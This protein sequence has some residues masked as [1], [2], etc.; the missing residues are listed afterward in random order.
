MLISTSICIVFTKLVSLY[1]KSE[2]TTVA[3]TVPILVTGFQAMKTM[4]PIWWAKVAGYDVEED[5]ME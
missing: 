4:I 2:W 1:N 5:S 3:T